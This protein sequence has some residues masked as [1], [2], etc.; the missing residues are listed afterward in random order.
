MRVEMLEPFQQQDGA[1]G[2]AH[3]K[4]RRPLERADMAVLGQD[5]QRDGQHD[6]GDFRP[7]IRALISRGLAVVPGDLRLSRSHSGGIFGENP[8]FAG[9]SPVPLVAPSPPL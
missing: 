2:Q 7:F 9:G 5:R 8:Y 1:G 3:Q 6:D 4:G